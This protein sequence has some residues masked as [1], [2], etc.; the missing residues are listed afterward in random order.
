[1]TY[2]TYIALPIVALTLIGSQSSIAEP[3]PESSASQNTCEAPRIFGSSKTLFNLKAPE[4]EESPA[5]GDIT[6]TENEVFGPDGRRLRVEWRDANG[7][8]SLAFMELYDNDDLPYGAFYVETGEL[9]PTLEKFEWSENGTVKTITYSQPDGEITG[10][11]R[12]F[13]DDRR[14]EVERRYGLKDD[15]S[16]SSS[17][18]VTYAGNNEVKYIWSRSDGSRSSAFVYEIEDLDV[19][20]NWTQRKVRRNGIETLREIRTLTYS[21]PP[22]A[23]NMK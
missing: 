22:C 15:G 5:V 4:D 9:N 19:Y 3:K 18:I 17:D 13:L 12:V 1:M 2:K 8:V 10:R 20:G 21:S 23:T 14:R 6:R 16:F 11:S 7:R